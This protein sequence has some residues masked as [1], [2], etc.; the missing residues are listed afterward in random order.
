MISKDCKKFFM[1]IWALPHCKK[2]CMSIFKNLSFYSVYLFLY[3]LPLPRYS[4]V[5]I[6]SNNL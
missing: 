4:A 6:L 3:N 5:P 1:G 2:K